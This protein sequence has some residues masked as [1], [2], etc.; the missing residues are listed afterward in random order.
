MRTYLL[1]LLGI[2]LPLLCSADWVPPEHPDAQGILREAESDIEAERNADAL[3]KLEWLY[4]NVLSFAPAMYGVRNSYLLVDWSKLGQSYP[5]AAQRLAAEREQAEADVRKGSA[6]RETFNRFNDVVAISRELKDDA[7]P[8]ELF[9][10]LDA[11]Q[12]EIARAVYPVAQPALVRAKAYPLCGKYLE[13]QKKLQREIELRRMNLKLEA[14]QANQKDMPAFANPRF[15][16]QT[17]L[18]VSLLMQNGRKEEAAKIAAEAL[19]E[20]DDAE[21]RAGMAEALKGRVPAP[22]PG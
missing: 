11:N 18:L 8:H 6:S 17:E 10:W 2:L 1:G 14:E 22:W 12:P 16:N 5:P 13:P 9:A 15:S 20:W 3:A 19:K 7:A 4:H 21:F